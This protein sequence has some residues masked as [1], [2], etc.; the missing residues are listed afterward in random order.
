MRAILLAASLTLTGVSGCATPAADEGKPAD[1]RVYV[2]GSNI[3]R[4]PDQPGGSPVY[5]VSGDDIRK[6]RLD[7]PNVIPPP[8][9]H[10]APG[11]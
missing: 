7:M 8:P 4:R 5:G 1:A 6:G 2:T 10:R 9:D 3:A 11:N